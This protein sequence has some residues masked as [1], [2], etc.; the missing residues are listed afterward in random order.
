MKDYF[1]GM[2][3]GCVLGA[4]AA[5]YYLSEEAKIRQGVNKGV[6]QVMARSGKIISNIEGEL[7]H[8]VRK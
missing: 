7:G 4:A 2:M 6:R 8:I 3:V 1:S 5:A